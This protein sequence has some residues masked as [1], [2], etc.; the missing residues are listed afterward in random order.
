VQGAG[1]AAFRA[2]AVFERP[3]D[4]LDALAD[5]RDAWSVA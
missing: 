3:E 1:V 2:E 4:A 5:R